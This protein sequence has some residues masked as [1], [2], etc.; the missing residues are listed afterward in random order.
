MSLLLRDQLRIRGGLKLLKECFRN[1]FPFENIMVGLEL[2]L[3]GHQLLERLVIQPFSRLAL[4]R[5]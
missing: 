2:E 5:Q 1:L 3:L 4:L